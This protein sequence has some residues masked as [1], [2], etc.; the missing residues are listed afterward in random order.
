MTT[1][2]AAGNI[3]VLGLGTYELT[4]ETAFEIVRHAL[5]VGYRHIDTAQAYDNEAEVGHGILASGLPRAHVFLTTK[6]WP[7]RFSRPKLIQSVDES[8]SKLG[9]DYIDLLLL[10]WPNPDIPLRETLEA[11][12]AVQSAGKTRFIGLSNFTIELMQQ[13]IAICGRGKLV[14]NQVEYHPYLDQSRVI[15][16]A[17]SLDMMTTAYRPIAK[18]RIFQE[19]T[20]QQIAQQHNKNAAQVTLRWLIQQGVIAIPR[21]SN[22][23][24]VSQNFEIFDFELTSDEMAAIDQL[25]GDRR[26]V[27]PEG[28]APDWDK[29]P[30]EAA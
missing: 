28:L 19:K 9:T 27:S 13:A 25:R 23:E 3:P 26:L 10:H 30:A 8:L 5:Q 6:V 2:A 22:P 14:T 11:L 12:M 20:L 24:H 29:P 15:A 1:A 16:A 4:G 7:D 18:G 21:S 17:H